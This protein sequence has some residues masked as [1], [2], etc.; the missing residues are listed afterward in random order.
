LKSISKRQG[1][2]EME[3]G[4]RTLLKFVITTMT[5]LSFS[6]LTNSAFGKVYV[7]I[8]AKGS[9]TYPLPSFFNSWANNSNINAN[10]NR[11]PLN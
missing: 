6:I 7:G 2:C 10:V 5:R 9:N 4:S 8:I 1:M 3:I 11:Y